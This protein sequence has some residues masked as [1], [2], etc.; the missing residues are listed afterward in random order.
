MP[1]TPLHRWDLTPAEAV[2]LQRELASQV[3]VRT[4]LTDFNLV[5]GAD[6]SYNRFD[7]TMYASVIVYRISDGEVVEVRDAVSRTEF[8]YIPGLLSFREGPSLL[9]AFAKLT[10]TPDAVMIDG[11]GIAHPRRL[12]IASHLGLW[13][14]IPTIG[15][16]KGL[17]TGKYKDLGERAGS[18]APLMAK[19]E[20]VGYAVRTKSRVTPVFVSAGHR[21]DLASAVRVILATARGYRIPEPTRR[22]HLRVNELRRSASC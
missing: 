21:I 18:L 15:C 13:L 4:P 7:P 17:L 9:Q 14:G 16:A 12:G 19:D 6:I 5:A 11:Q 1:I 2:Q 22:A 8:P 3:E 10:T 20:Q